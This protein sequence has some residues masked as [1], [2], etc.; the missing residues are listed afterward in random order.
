MSRL[1]GTL[2]A[3]N[4]KVSERRELGITWHQQEIARID[5]SIRRG[6]VVFWSIWWVLVFVAVVY[7]AVHVL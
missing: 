1:A 4:A 6:R 3:N 5:R 2:A 7:G